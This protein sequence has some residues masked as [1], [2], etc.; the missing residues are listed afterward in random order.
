M[1]EYGREIVYGAGCGGIEVEGSKMFLNSGVSASGAGADQSMFAVWV[2]DDNAFKSGTAGKEGFPLPDLVFQDEQTNTLTGGNLVGPG[3]SDSTGQLPGITTRRDSHGMDVTENGQY[4]HV[5]DRIQNKMEVFDV[6]TYQRFGYDL[7]SKSGHSGRNG[8]PG[9]CMAKSV[10]DDSKLP[11]NDPAPDLFERT[12][13]GKYMMIALRGPAPVSVGH[14]AQGS[15]PGVGIVELLPN[16]KF[17]KLVDVLRTTNTVDDAP[18]GTIPGGV[19]YSGAERS[20]VHGAIVV[21]RP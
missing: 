15:C 8:Q 13:D 3:P 9:A 21:S 4:L 19:A 16:Q 18:L 17:G 10:T 7:T 12:P 5:V 1:A 11:L 14:S 20:D 2:F 6:N